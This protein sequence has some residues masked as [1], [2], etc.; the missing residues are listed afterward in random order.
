M[1]QGNSFPNSSFSHN[2][3]NQH[4]YTTGSVYFVDSGATNTSDGNPGHNPSKPLATLNGAMDRVTANQ[5]DIIY[6]MPGHAE[7]L[8]DATDVVCDVAGVK[9][10]GIGEGRTKP[11][12]TFS[13]TAGS[14]EMNAANT[15]IENVRFLAS[16]SAVVV[17][18]NVD[19]DGITIRD[20]EWDW[21]AT[22]DDFLIMV[23]ATA[24]DYVTIENN[25]MI[26]E[27]AAGAAEAIIFRGSDHLTIRGNWISGDFSAAAIFG[28]TDTAETNS[29]GIGLLIEGNNIYQQDAAAATNGIDVMVAATGLI[30]HNNIGTLFATA[31]A[32]AGLDPGSCLCV[33]NYVVNAIDEHAVRTPIVSST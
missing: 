32:N 26:A 33:E 17:G 29:L 8:D 19:A 31:A 15:L 13:G 4:S 16:V 11:A 7:S 1:P 30:A 12:F 24:V 27:S 10:I 3:G 20:C 22:G 5:G 14:F 25:R 6:L 2:V 9:I 18:V 21:D 28:T 23:D